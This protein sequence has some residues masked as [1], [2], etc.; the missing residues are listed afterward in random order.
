MLAAFCE[1]ES[2]ILGVGR[3]AH[4]ETDRARAIL[5]MLSALGVEA[6]ISDDELIVRGISL[7]RRMLTGQLLRGGKYASHGDHR[8][9]MALSVASLGAS[10]PVEIDDTACVAKSY[11]GYI[12]L[13][14]RYESI[15]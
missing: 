3:L 13:F 8:M 12:E 6:S 11:P 10:S 1:G 9:V 2:H 4:K 7:A 5:E 15:R 14:E